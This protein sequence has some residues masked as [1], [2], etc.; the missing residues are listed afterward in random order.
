MR[1]YADILTT[2]QEFKP[3]AVVHFAAYALVGESMENPLKYYNNNITSG[4]NLL[5]AM[6]ATNCKRIVFSSSCA[7]YG[8]PAK[9]LI[10][11]L[12]KQNPVNPYGHSKYLFEQILKSVA[13]IK[14]INYT[15]FRYF[16]AAGACGNLGEEHVPETHLIPNVVDAIMNN[17]EVCI[18]GNDYDTAD[19]SCI[20]DYVHVI[21]LASAH[22]AALKNSVYGEFNLG[23]GNGMSNFNIVSEIEA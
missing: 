12:D 15:I 19:G 22:I 23:T 13:S 17:K 14:H 7:T 8:I 6:E 21:D 16:N 10:S 1:N 20:R 2:M 18:Y 3:D 9:V 4:I 11:E 5:M